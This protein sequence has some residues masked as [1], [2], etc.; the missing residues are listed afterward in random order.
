MSDKEYGWDTSKYKLWDMALDRTQAVDDQ[1]KRL[2]G[3]EVKIKNLNPDNELTIFGAAGRYDYPNILINSGKS[4]LL[5]LVEDLDRLNKNKPLDRESVLGH[6]MI[7]VLE[8]NRQSSRAM[9]DEEKYRHNTIS[10]A[11]LNPRHSD[12]SKNQSWEDVIA[13]YEAINNPEEIY[14]WLN[15]E[16]RE[17]GLSISSTYYEHALENAREFMATD[18]T[19]QPKMIDLYKRTI[20]DDFKG[21]MY[22]DHPRPS[23]TQK[24]Q[25]SNRHQGDPDVIDIVKGLELSHKYADALEGLGQGSVLTD[26]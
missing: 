17:K 14:E 19:W 1:L 23:Q 25:Y 5:G 9:T 21:T 24:Y 10:H 13:P 6:E 22:E 26:E 8:A 15:F 11:R 4:Q 7:H 2:T 3:G 12:R 18:P 20:L 16:G